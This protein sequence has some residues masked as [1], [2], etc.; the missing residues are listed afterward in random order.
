[1]D[2]PHFELKSCCWFIT[3][4]LVITSSPSVVID[5]SA[6]LPQVLCACHSLVDLG[7][8]L[9]GDSLEL[10]ALRALA[11]SWA[12]NSTTSTATQLPEQAKA[13]AKQAKAKSRWVAFYQPSGH[14]II[15]TLLSA[16]TC[17]PCLQHRHVAAARRAAPPVRLGA[18]AH[19]R[20]RARHAAARRRQSR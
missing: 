1:M 11:P 15:M 9:G 7:G 8:K 18:A 3:V 17:P 13:G 19:E 6:A 16:Y 12:Y 2:R 5:H 14:R 20:R 10:S 4:P